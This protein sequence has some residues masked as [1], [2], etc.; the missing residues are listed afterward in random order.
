VTVDVVKD[1]GHAFMLTKNGLT[2]D[3][4]MVEWLKS[5]P[6]APGCLGSAAG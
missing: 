3:D 6:E 4:K 1:A 2:G 5:R